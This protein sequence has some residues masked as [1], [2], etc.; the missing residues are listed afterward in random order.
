MPIAIAKNDP[1]IFTTSIIFLNRDWEVCWESPFENSVWTSSHLIA[2]S[3]SWDGGAEC[4]LNISL[5]CIVEWFVQIVSGAGGD[6]NGCVNSDSN[7]GFWLVERDHVTLT[8]AFDWSGEI[9]DLDT[10]LWMV[11]RDFVTW[12]LTFY[13][14]EEICDLDTGF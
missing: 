8:L 10:G 13:W 11:E 12:I 14:S 1:C 7:S 2:L 3:L 4:F 5:K 6:A 9:C